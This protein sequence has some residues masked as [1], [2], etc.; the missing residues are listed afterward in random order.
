MQRFSLI[1]SI[2]GMYEAQAKMSERTIFRPQ[3]H[4]PRHRIDPPT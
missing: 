4:W 2:R 1:M 3:T